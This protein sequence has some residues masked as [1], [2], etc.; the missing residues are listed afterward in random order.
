MAKV[1]SVSSFLFTQANGK[2]S[3][4]LVIEK[5]MMLEVHTED[6][7]PNLWI[8]IQSL[9]CPKYTAKVK[10]ALASHNFTQMPMS[11]LP[12][13]QLRQHWFKWTETNCG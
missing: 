7:K 1:W 4:Y 2:Y 5:E 6:T 12:Q 9:F 13:V 3:V 10:L 8:L 11:T